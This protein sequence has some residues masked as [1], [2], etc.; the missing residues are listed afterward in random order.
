MRFCPFCAQN[1]GISP[2]YV[3]SYWLEGLKL[4]ELV[5]PTVSHPWA[6]F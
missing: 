2:K 5:I 1:G 6:K 4:G 3:G